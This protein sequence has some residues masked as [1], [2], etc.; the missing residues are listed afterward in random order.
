[1][2]NGIWIYTQNILLIAKQY[3][4]QITRDNDDNDEIWFGLFLSLV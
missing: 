2:T 3:Y 1:M 4:E